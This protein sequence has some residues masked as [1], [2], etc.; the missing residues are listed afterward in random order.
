MATVVYAMSG[1]GR[2]HATRALTVIEALRT[3]HTIKV[4][5]YGQ[6]AEFLEPIYRGS[7]VEV[8]RLPGL[9]F[10]YT[11]RGS[12][13]YFR[14]V[15]AAAPYLLQLDTRVEQLCRELARDAPSL[16]ITDFEPIVPRAALR[17]GVPFVSLDHQHFLTAYDLRGL[18][19]RLRAYARC[20][21]PW[22][23]RY[24]RGQTHSIVSSFYDA[25]LLPHGGAVTR[26]GVLLRPEILHAE[27][28]P[29]RHLVA[30]VRRQIRGHVIQ[31]LVDTGH[32]VKV[33]GLGAQPSR[34]RVSFHAIDPD[35]FVA[36]LASSLALVSTAGNQLVGEA[37]YL[38]KPVFA[39]PEDG[40]FEQAINAHFLKASG[41]GETLPVRAVTG[42]QLRGF[43]GRV[44]WLRTRIDRASVCGNRAALTVLREQLQLAQGHALCQPTSR[45]AVP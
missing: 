5:A 23:Q 8:R 6:A 13:A 1:E 10:H 34:G 15:L 41:M 11:A 3:A 30:Y 40:N 28:T 37:L 32:P 25:P 18:P 43:L 7:D 17:L 33:Y 39:M 2:G 27:P 19:L 44:A 21:A 16:V 12:V 26:V 20:L 14:T 36:D 4:Y 9:Q 42:E 24:Y 45:Q 31:A 22:V 38:G 35:R 29:G